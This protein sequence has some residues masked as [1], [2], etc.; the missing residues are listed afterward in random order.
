MTFRRSPSRASQL[1]RHSESFAPVKDKSPVVRVG[2]FLQRS[3]EHGLS[4]VHS[5]PSHGLVALQFS[6]TNDLIRFDRRSPKRAP[7]ARKG[8]EYGFPGSQLCP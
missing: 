5:A 1:E 3:P 6:Y 8:H 7:S 2:V 4:A